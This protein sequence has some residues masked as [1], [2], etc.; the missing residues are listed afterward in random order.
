MSV[1][2][3]KTLATRTAARSFVAAL[4]V[5]GC[6]LVSSGASALDCS[7]AYQVQQ[8]FANGAA[9]E[10]C[11]EEQAREGMVLRDVTYTSPDGVSRRV[12]YQANVSQIHVPYDDDGARYHDVSDY[13]LGGNRLNDLT[14]ADC[15][16]GTLI[17]NG[18]KD[19]FCKTLHDA[20]SLA[21]ENEVRY[22]EALSLF[23]VSHVGAYNYI[24]EW[25]FFDD[26]TIEPAMGATGRLQRYTSSEA[27]GWPVRTGSSPVGVSHIHN[28][29]WRLDFDLDGGDDD[30]FEELEFVDGP[31]GTRTLNSTQFTTETARSVNPST[32]RFWRVYDGGTQNNTGRP[33]SYDVLALETGHRDVGPTFEPWTFN[34]IYAT[35]YRACERFVSHNPSDLGGGCSS[36]GDVTDFVSGEAIDTDDL[37]LWFGLTFHHTPRDED[38][39]Y[40]NA[41][42]NRFRLE[43]RDWFDTTSTNA[44][45]VVESI[46]DRLEVEGTAVNFSAVATDAEGDDLTFSATGLP[47]GISIDAEGSISGTLSAPGSYA[48]IITAT[49]PMGASGDTSF[50]W[51]VTSIDAC[52]SC[53]NFV[54]VQ[55]ES[56]GGQDRD[57]GVV[58]EEQGGTLLLEG[59]TWRRTLETYTI[60]ATTVLEF[61]FASTGEGEIHGIGFDADNT[62]S[63][64][65]IFQLYGIQNYG[66]QNYNN[67]EPSDFVTYQIPVGSF[68]TG[69]DMAMVFVNDHDS[70][71]GNNSRFRNVRVYEPVVNTAPA[72]QAPGD[73]TG[74]TGAAVSLLLV[75]S[76]IDGDNLQYSAQGLPTGLV[77]ASATGEIS[78][79]LNAAGTFSVLATVADPAGA[80]ASQSFSWTV[81]TPVTNSAPVL[82]APGLQTSETGDVVSLALTATDDDGDVL[83]WSAS[84][85]PTGLSLNSTTG[86]IS[87]TPTAAG[88]ATVTVTVTDGDLSASQSFDWRIVANVAL[89][90]TA[91]QVSE[92]QIG[93]DLGASKA[94]D[95]NNNGDFGAFTLTH[96]DFAAQAW[97]EIDLGARYEL[98]RIEL[99]NRT[100]CCAESLQNFHV[101][102]SDVPFASTLLEVAQGQPGVLDIAQPDIAPPQT[103]LA[104]GRSGRF[105]RV[106]LEGS[107][108][109]QL[110]EV[111]IYGYPAAGGNDNFAPAVTNPGAQANVVG[112]AVSLQLSALDPEN[113]TLSFSSA[114]LP[115]GL[116]LDSVSGLISGTVTSANTFSVTV[117]VNDG[118]NNTGIAFE[119]LVS[120]DA[121]PTNVALGAIAVQSSTLDI[122]VD[123]SAGNAIDGNSN[124][125]FGAGSLTH[126]DFNNQPWWQVDLGAR[127]TI[128]SVNVFNRE[129]CCAESLSDFYVLVSEVP[130]GSSSL[131]ELLADATVTAV[132]VP[133]AGGR[134]SV[135][136]LNA[137]GRY[138]RV[139]L[140]DSEYLQLAEV[141]V[142][143]VPT[144]GGGVNFAPTL[145]NPGAQIADL[146]DTVDLLLT[147]SDPEGDA[148]TF[149]AV[150]LPPGLEIEASTGAITGSLTAAG[151][152][153]VSLS[154]SDG[155]SS[156][157][158][159]VSWNVVDPSAPTNLAP[160]GIASQSST[161]DLGLDFS[162]DNAIDGDRGGEFPTNAITHTDVSAEAWWEIDLGAVYDLTTVRIFNREDC[163]A[164]SLADFHVFVS[165]VPFTGS[166]V[167]ATLAQ[168]G[169]TGAFVAGLGGRETTIPLSRSGRYV[170]VQLTAVEY[171]QLAEVE[172]MGLAQ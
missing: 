71:T 61:E 29:Y 37:V 114:G 24:P 142:L 57:S 167:A 159:E 166:S 18:S 83:T 147:A 115:D 98:S 91:S 164:E 41:H 33:I 140:P 143:G 22:G 107:D 51:T 26:G 28:Y 12:L 94:N 19:V 154:V 40:M 124:G 82:V 8:S 49:D 36:N 163:C 90:G 93:I 145:S 155:N 7:S 156:T 157:Q 169:V 4:F 45:P 35:T 122:P 133:G 128:S 10:M 81:S 129:D 150:G 134:P 11:W 38:E 111:E 101:L 50:I 116:S 137:T 52:T 96:T 149:S 139:Q 63:Q 104:L 144:D 108:Y 78:G 5:I 123:L 99:F 141:E 39:A 6:M 165:D 160:A 32:Q 53:V 76:D 65:Q 42:W 59:N 68:Y 146:G 72:L 46:T 54:S 97:W 64:S 60:A 77:V 44:V 89:T 138:V 2:R 130:F 14:Q 106:Q 70:G 31:N 23:S 136:N 152:F 66:Q 92:L 126:T 17:K 102:V 16:E 62:L 120:N 171:L 117:E 9:W 125:N 73:Q 148:L 3:I 109:L 1:T 161:L 162:A 135:V 84:G 79:T 55:T 75:A 30:R 100:D 47:L 113:D 34:D 168:P 87:G 86:A 158:V 88:A 127:F 131:Q 48:A 67:Y 85:L 153:N 170:R 21:T 58:I 112:S 13:G 110:A 25:R 15:P 56:Y 103:T 95:G 43:P 69:T 27:F 119:W 172:V 20:A 80:S 74:E 118:Q 105:V 151:L 121:L 132:Q